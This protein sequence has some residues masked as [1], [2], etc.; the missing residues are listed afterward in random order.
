MEL[1]MK[2]ALL[3]YAKI[4]LLKLN[5]PL[6]FSARSV[7]RLTVTD[8]NS[9]M[10]IVVQIIPWTSMSRHFLRNLFWTLVVNTNT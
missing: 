8:S 7:H 4:K 9:R 2:R 5:Y 1:K 10:R 3:I 6:L